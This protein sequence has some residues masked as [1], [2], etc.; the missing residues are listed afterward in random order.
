MILEFPN[1]DLDYHSEDPISHLNFVELS[2]F[3]S[4]G[5]RAK[6]NIEHLKIEPRKCK[7]RTVSRLPNP[8]LSSS[9]LCTSEIGVEFIATFVTIIMF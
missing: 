4:L 5:F 7:Q 9:K 3:F 6:Q 2:T 8:E 1:S